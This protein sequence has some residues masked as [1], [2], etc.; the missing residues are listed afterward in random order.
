[1]RITR[2]KLRTDMVTK[3]FFET[4]KVTRVR[5]SVHVP[6]SFQEMHDRDGDSLSLDRDRD[7]VET[8]SIS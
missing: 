7:R 8:L 3:A 2:P 4:A 1:M 6:I 5:S